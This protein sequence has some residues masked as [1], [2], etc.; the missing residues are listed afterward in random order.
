MASPGDPG[1]PPPLPDI[2]NRNL[3]LEDAINFANNIAGLNPDAK[4]L[5]DVIRVS[6]QNAEIFKAFIEQQNEHPLIK[7]KRIYKNDDNSSDFIMN[8]VKDLYELRCLLHQ[9]CAQN[10]HITHPDSMGPSITMTGTALQ[11]VRNTR[12]NALWNRPIIPDHFL[13]KFILRDN[14]I[15]QDAHLTNQNALLRTIR[16][17]IPTYVNALANKFPQLTL[18]K[19]THILQEQTA[20]ARDSQSEII[21]SICITSRALI[22]EMK[23]EYLKNSSSRPHSGVWAQNSQ[24]T[25]TTPL[26][27]DDTITLINVSFPQ[28]THA[29][30]SSITNDSTTHDTIII[31]TKTITSTA[32]HNRLNK[33]LASY[34]HTEKT[35]NSLFVLNSYKLAYEHFV[36]DNPARSTSPIP[37]LPPP[38]AYL[39]RSE[40]PTAFIKLHA[41][42]T[43]SST[44]FQLTI[45][46]IQRDSLI[47]ALNG[48]P[49]NSK[50][51]A[52][53]ATT[54]TLFCQRCASREHTADS[55]TVPA[56]AP[57]KRV[58]QMQ[59]R[60][61]LQA[62]SRC[63]YASLCRLLKTGNC[64]FIH[65]NEQGYSS[66]VEPICRFGGNCRRI[67]S[68]GCPHRHNTTNNP[69]PTVQPVVTSDQQNTQIVEHHLVA[70][71]EQESKQQDTE[72][73][74]TPTD[75]N[76]STDSYTDNEDMEDRPNKAKDSA[77]SNGKS[78]VPTITR[79][80]R[81]R[82]QRS[83]SRTR[84]RY[85][86]RRRTRSRSERALAINDG[87]TP[88]KP[89]NKRGKTAPDK[90]SSS[91]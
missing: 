22:A 21:I 34:F 58:Q 80:S 64:R 39:E 82:S 12:K 37:D 85:Q 38:P 40:L 17:R 7:Y 70:A 76:D 44:A 5:G 68:G 41:R 32:D 19:Q 27:I 46:Y 8:N 67:Q 90:D 61:E 2:I 77:T 86:H 73:Q 84:S 75:S 43:L 62:R 87:G 56:F 65:P 42:K 4:G 50:I 59:A 35:N 71:A 57:H 11:D 54:D 48:S 13:I 23:A 14:A 52:F 15:T 16:S 88:K 18:A 30:T 29:L 91:D 36:N 31:P 74:K 25:R 3:S 69:T 6:P 53:I 10:K 47:A 79:D 66:A 24:P 1:D 78:S 83:R 72:K 33:I 63:R 45:T 49:E 55:C 26:I 81:S 20:F 51:Q 28:S 60:S 89:A 9:Y